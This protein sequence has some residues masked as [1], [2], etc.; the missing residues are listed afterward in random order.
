MGFKSYYRRKQIEIA[1]QY[2]YLGFIICTIREEIIFQ[3]KK[4]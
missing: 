1:S 2:N 3:N 4:W